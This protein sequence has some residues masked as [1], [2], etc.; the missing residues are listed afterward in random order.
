MNR[1]KFIV[2]TASVVSVALAGCVGDEDEET[3]TTGSD[4]DGDDDSGDADAGTGEGLVI[5]EHELV[6]DDFTV[7]IGGILLNDTGEEQSYVEVKSTVYDEDDVRID[8]FFTNTTD[9]PDGEQ[10]RF[11]IP[12]LEDAEDVDRYELEAST[13][14][15]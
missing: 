13:S 8:D 12:V 6:E 4:A 7:Q 10:W 14:A 11:E 3:T 9:L 1:R 2:G 15:F 5:E